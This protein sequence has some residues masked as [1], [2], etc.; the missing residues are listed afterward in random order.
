MKLSV[1]LNA[2]QERFVDFCLQYSH[3]SNNGKIPSVWKYLAK[4]W[5]ISAVER[6]KICNAGE[7]FEKFAY[8]AMV[9]R[10]LLLDLHGSRR[11]L[12]VLWSILGIF[13]V[14][15]E[16]ALPIVIHLW[17]NPVP[18]RFLLKLL[19][20]HFQFKCHD[21]YILKYFMIGIKFKSYIVSADEF[22]CPTRSKIFLPTDILT[23]F[24]F[25]IISGMVKE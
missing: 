10:S 22:A 24:Y 2:Q 11:N 23:K 21:N 17:I 12:K 7:I 6:E 1:L 4:L 5:F 25:M 3:K 19:C 9:A 13:L 15:L 14:L 18:F 8:L 16:T 20:T